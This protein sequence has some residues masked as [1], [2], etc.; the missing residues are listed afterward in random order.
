MNTLNKDFFKLLNG[1]S[2]FV[3]I[4]DIMDPFLDFDLVKKSIEFSEKHKIKFL[5]PIGHV[6]GTGYSLL[7]NKNLLEKKIKLENIQPHYFEHDT[8]EKYNNQFNLYKFKRL[9]I[10]LSLIKK[11]KLLYK[12]S[13]KEII[14]YLNKPDV[15][16]FLMGITEN[17]KLKKYKNC[18][19]CKGSLKPIFNSLSQPMI[20]YVS[21]KYPHYHECFNCGLIVATPRIS[22]ECIHLIY[23]EWDKQDFSNSS[24]NPYKENSRRCNFN[25]I[26]TNLNRNLKIID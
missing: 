20:G 24:N 6:G 16:E 4:L 14:S 22:P 9:K 8:Q 13:I 1:K 2:K 18:P 19:H 10:F 17:V 15:Y 11:N 3:L 23:D 7:I 5:K 12:Y 25:Y 26:N 21:S